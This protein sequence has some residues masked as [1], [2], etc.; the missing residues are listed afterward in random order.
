MKSILSGIAIAWIG[1]WTVSACAQARVDGQVYALLYAW[2]NPAAQ[3]QW[4]A[5]QGLRLHVRPLATADLSFKTNVRL[6]RRGDPAA[7][8]ERVYNAYLDWR[9][10]GRSVSLRLGRQFLYKGV[11]NGSL[12]AL[13]VQARPTRKLELHV[14]GGLAVP[15]DRPFALQSWREGGVLGGY[16]AYRFGPPARL[17]L[18]YVQRLRN[19]RIAW[20]QAGVALTGAWKQK[21]YYQAQFDYNLQRSDYQ[22]MRYRL[23]YQAQPWSLSAEFNSQKPRVFEDSFFNV[24]E[25]VAFHQLRGGLTLDVLSYQFG[26]QYLHTI[27]ERDETNDEVIL[28]AGNRWGTVGVV[29]QAGFGGDNVGLFGQVR[30]DVLPGLTV[31]LHS[32]HYTYERRS[33]ALSE[34]ATAFSG[35]VLYRPVRALSIQAEV[36]ESMNSFYDNDLRGLVRVSYA[37]NVR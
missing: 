25:L 36:Q 31:K 14:V 28:T 37:F 3:Q 35:G 18:S 21:L 24:F 23:T 10:P 34:D 30:Y 20:R 26:V 16:A 27:Y 17:D 6:A 29:Y 12:D 5:Y 4:D 8:G 13:S 2:E 32:S 9:A 15:F 1:L 19:D 11:V 7:W 33:I 22:G